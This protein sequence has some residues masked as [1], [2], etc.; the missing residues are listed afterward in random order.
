MTQV[1][2]LATP[3]TSVVDPKLF[4]SDQDLDLALTL[5]SDP[6]C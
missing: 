1:R 3:T 4:F 2:L 5:F 6:D